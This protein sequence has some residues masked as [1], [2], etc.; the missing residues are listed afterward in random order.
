MIY[1]VL[2]IIIY[3]FVFLHESKATNITKKI[4][5]SLVCILI[6][7]FGGGRYEVGY[8]WF[9]YRDLFY[10]INSISDAIYAREEIFFTIFIYFSKSIY[11]SFE[12]FIFV[13]FLFSFLIKAVFIYRY[14]ANYFVS[15]AVYYY[16]IFM[17]Y[18]INGLRQ[19]VAIS[20][21]LISFHYLLKGKS[22]TSFIV[23]IIATQFHITSVA[24]LPFILLVRY[25]INHRIIYYSILL[26]AVLYPPIVENTVIPLYFEQLFQF[27]DLSHYSTYI[28]R[29]SSNT[30]FILFN[31]PLIQRIIVL[32]MV[33]IAFE[34]IKINYNIKYNLFYAYSISVL[35]YTLLIFNIEFAARLS[36]I[37]R[38]SEIILLSY[39][40]KYS[41]G[42][43]K[44]AFLIM[45]I[46]M[47][48]FALW[49]LLSVEY[50]GLLP[51]NNILLW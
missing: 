6:L 38:V 18:D 28:E 36:F 10:A 42:F 26:F 33:F 50:G 41:N 45:I 22:I 13:L 39:V 46:S 40:V 1:Y 23:A 30:T 27:Q 35:I 29:S 20:F 17:I 47:S 3:F 2:I 15:L 14:S 11:N 48:I 9:S 24:F 19:G 44:Y 31:V 16:T 34:S 37:F 32:T 21:V 12:Y 5:Y 25:K 49:R 51:Y 4:W 8:D 7:V 43:L